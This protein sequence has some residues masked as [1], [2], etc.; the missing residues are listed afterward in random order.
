MAENVMN[1]INF[2]SKNH[3]T[4]IDSLRA[5]AA[6]LVFFYHSVGVMIKPN[7][8]FP[9]DAS[10]YLLSFV[11]TGATGVTLFFVISSFLLSIPF[12]LK[13]DNS[14]V[15]FFKKRLLRILPMYFFIVLIAGLLAGRNNPMEVVRSFFFLF[16]AWA[17][18]PFSTPWW[19]LRTEMEFYILLGLLMP[20][21][22]FRK[23]RPI[24]LASIAAIFIGRYFIFAHPELSGSNRYL[25]NI[26]FQSAVSH[27]PTFLIGIAASIIYIKFGASMKAYFFKSKIFNSVVSDFIF[28]LILAV[29]AFVLR[30]VAIMG[31]MIHAELKWPQHHTYEA[32]LWS[33]VLLSLIVLP[34]RIKSLISNRFLARIG[35]TT[36][37]FYLINLPVMFYIDTN[38]LSIQKGFTLIYFG[39]LL[40]ILM[41]TLILS[42]LSYR[43]IERPFLRIKDR[44]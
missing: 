20:L 18:F 38:L 10:G 33:L 2:N 21:I 9:H 24:L 1:P 8:A 41:V 44:L 14:R 36:Y 25:Y 22:H 7:P 43:F 29:L 4:E 40:L 39:K 37:S 23:G 32:F 17:L 31:S 5:V 3:S 27:A 42:F 34:M 28:F 30:K 16:D 26:L 13:P 35:E 19:S 6:L 11:F 15:S 12:Y